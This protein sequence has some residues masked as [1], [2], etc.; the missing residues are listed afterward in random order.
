M[1]TRITLLLFAT[2]PLPAMAGGPIADVICYPRAQLVERMSSQYGASVAGSGLR[3]MEMMMEVWTD[4]K[5]DW[6][7]VQ[8]YT[9][10]RSC[11]VAMGEFWE[12]TKAD[13]KG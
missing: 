12:A 13:A 11:I 6:T 5:G 10:G 3:N 2:L 8:N 9:D 7:L 4:P 1:T